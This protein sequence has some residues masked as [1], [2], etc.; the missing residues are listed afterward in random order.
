M[1]NPTRATVAGRTYRDLQ[2]KARRDRRPF[3]ELLSLYTL[4]GFLA[5]L[6]SSPHV[7]NLILKGGLLL[8]AY[9]A[10]R[11]TRDADF[12]AR[13]LANQ[14]PVITGVVQDIAR[15]TIDDGLSFDA[16]SA[17]GQTIR[18]D[19]LYGGV[20][21][22]LDARLATAHTRLKV[23]VNIGDPIS[24][25]PQQVNVPRLLHPGDTIEL[26]GYPLHMVH[27]EKIIT[28]IQR[29]TVNTRWRDFAD[30]YLLCRAQPVDGHLLHDALTM[31]A[32]HRR[33][34]LA[35]LVVVLAG[36]ADVPGV[37]GKWA[38]WRRKQQLDDRLPEP[39]ADV[40]EQVFAFADPAITGAA[41]DAG[42][43]PQHLAWVAP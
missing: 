31:V 8:A 33:V 18:D 27:S 13:S 4:E 9:D 26:L 20:R 42:W 32:G 22:H 34:A 3:D 28:A 1:T 23:D 16:D 37:L 2:S 17:R 38:A 39:F 43:R 12:A 41:S 11:P 10:R 15:I 36:Y 29:G 5:R 6:T 40:L 24:P 7:G 14:V 30:I 21:V 19:D 25:G 35:P